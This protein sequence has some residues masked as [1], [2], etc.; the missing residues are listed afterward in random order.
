MTSLVRGRSG[1]EGGGGRGGGRGR[2]GEG[3]KGQACYFEVPR[4]RIEMYIYCT[5]GS[6]SSET[7]LFLLHVTVKDL[8][9]FL[10]QAAA[11]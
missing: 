5:L 3:G 4:S 7:I 10:L 11:V 9:F 1:Q 6:E 8:F 2:W